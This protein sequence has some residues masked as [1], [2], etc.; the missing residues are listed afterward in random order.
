RRPVAASLLSNRIA[1]SVL[2]VG[3]LIALYEVD[4]AFGKESPYSTLAPM[5][6]GVVVWDFSYE[7]GLISRV[8]KSRPFALAGTLS[9]SIYLSHAIVQVA[10]SLVEHGRFG[11]RYVTDG[12]VT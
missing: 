5:L 2:E 4:S 10:S 3:A 11:L 7:T 8:L 1:V 9:Y 12:D 6:S